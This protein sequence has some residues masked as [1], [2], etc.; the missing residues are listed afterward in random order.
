M[1][2]DTLNSATSE[3][4]DFSRALQRQLAYAADAL[5]VLMALYRDSAKVRGV[6]H[7]ASQF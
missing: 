5:E 4:E 7:P 3:Q 2:S 1:F 6:Q